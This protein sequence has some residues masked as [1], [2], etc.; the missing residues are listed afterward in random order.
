L[1]A[2]TAQE[3]FTTLPEGLVFEL[4][5]SAQLDL[6]DL[7]AAGRP[8]QA[9]NRFGDTI[10]LKKLTPDYLALQ[11]A[12][13][14]F[15]LIVLKMINDSPLYCLIHTVC[16]PVCDSRVAFYSAAWKSLPW[17]AFLAPAPPD[18]F[19]ENAA[20]LPDV[21]FTQWIYDSDADVLQ[22]IY[23]TLDY[24]G[25]DERERLRPFLRATGKEFR[26]TGMRFE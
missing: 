7:Y 8:A 25:P 2:Q 1:R 26:W 11:S 3:V 10:V 17:E 6:V 20:D 13:G 5:A 24:L 18:F 16:A 9:V 23:T 12:G 19:I 14:T 21:C 4:S 15:Q 22:Q